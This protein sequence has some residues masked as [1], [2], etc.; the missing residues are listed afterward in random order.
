MVQVLL[1][2]AAITILAVAGVFAINAIRL[3]FKSEETKN[4]NDA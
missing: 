2:A 3:I 4:D 1:T